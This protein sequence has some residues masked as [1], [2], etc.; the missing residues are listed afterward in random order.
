[1]ASYGIDVAWLMMLGVVISATIRRYC[2]SSDAEV[3]ELRNPIHMQQFEG[4]QTVRETV[5][6]SSVPVDQLS[7]IIIERF[8]QDCLQ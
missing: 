1:M 5:A 7:H 8:V 4:R 6:A 2:L 3:V